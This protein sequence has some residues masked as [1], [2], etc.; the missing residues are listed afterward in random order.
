MLYSTSSRYSIT[1]TKQSS[2]EEVLCRLHEKKHPRSEY[3]TEIL[4]SESVCKSCERLT[5]TGLH[6]NIVYIYIYIIVYIKAPNQTTA[7]FHQNEAMINLHK[8]TNFLLHFIL[9]TLTFN[10]QM[11]SC[12]IHVDD[13]PIHYFIVIYREKQFYFF[14]L[15]IYSILYAAKNLEYAKKNE[16]I[17]AYFWFI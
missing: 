16:D 7:H 15:S 4:Y 11:Y 6:I 10:V 13:F 14:N 9:A 5:N 2:I 1:Q 8:M 17:F 3:T 12:Q